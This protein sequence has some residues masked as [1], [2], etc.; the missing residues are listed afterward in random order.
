MLTKSRVHTQRDGTPQFWKIFY[1]CNYRVSSL[2]DFRS[3]LSQT[4]Y[5]QRIANK[6][7]LLKN[8][9]AKGVWL[10]DASVVALYR[11]VKKIPHMYSAL[12]TSWKLYTRDIVTSATPD[13]VICIGNELII[14]L[15]GGD[16][17][18]QAADIKKALIL[19]RNL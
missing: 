14:L 5:E 8:L 19:A 16:K 9:K 11:N 1:S 12:E 13:H 10:V 7:Q 6:I 18:T 15:A 4:E 2:R 3:I 17:S